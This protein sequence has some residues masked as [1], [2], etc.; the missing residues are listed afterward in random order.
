M[1]VTKQATLERVGFGGRLGFGSVHSVLDLGQREFE[2]G[3]QALKPG[4]QRVSG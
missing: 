3:R 1:L 2:G 4:R